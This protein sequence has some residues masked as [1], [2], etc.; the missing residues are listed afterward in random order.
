ME[1]VYRLFDRHCRSDTPRAKPPKLCQ[2]VLRFK[3]LGRILR[4]LEA[5]NLEKALTFLDDKLP[6]PT[7]NEVERGN[8]RHR[9]MQKTVYR[10]RTQDQIHNRIALDTLRDSPKERRTKTIKVLHKAG[11]LSVLARW[12]TSLDA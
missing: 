10:I 4:E 9:K 6:S 5:S 8:R 7:F 11:A 1:E 12:H 2:R 3:A